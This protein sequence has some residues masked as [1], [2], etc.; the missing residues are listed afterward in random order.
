MTRF[1]SVEERYGGSGR[2]GGETTDRGKIV[3]YVPSGQIVYGRG[4]PGVGQGGESRIMANKGE[5][6]A[7]GTGGGIGD[8]HMNS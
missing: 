4:S 7:R 2:E 8:S 3:G 6:I 1:L 5:R